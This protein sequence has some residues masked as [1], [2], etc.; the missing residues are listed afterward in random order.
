MK[1]RRVFKFGEGSAIL[2]EKAKLQVVAD[3]IK[4]YREIDETKNPQTAENL[5]NKIINSID[6]L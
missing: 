4:L 2:K 5:K 1:K 3:Y 6:K